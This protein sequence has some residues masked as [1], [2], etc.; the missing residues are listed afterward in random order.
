MGRNICTHAISFTNIVEGQEQLHLWSNVL[1]FLTCSLLSQFFIMKLF[2]S[3]YSLL[4]WKV[5]LKCWILRPEIF[6]AVVKWF[7]PI[8]E[9]YQGF[10]SWAGINIIPIEP[11][12]VANNFH[13][14]N[15]LCVLE[16][17]FLIGTFTL[18]ALTPLASAAA[19][20]VIWGICPSRAET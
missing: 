13:P 19:T 10:A 17:G 9:R 1:V 6:S 18:K 7:Q 11:Q 15:L 14:R 5:H 8:T 2:L 4:H 12:S 3:L 20:C 16:I